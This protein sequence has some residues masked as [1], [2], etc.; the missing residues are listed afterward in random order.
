MVWQRNYF[1]H[2]IRSDYALGRVR[3]Y[4]IANPSRWTLDRYNE[5]HTGP[6]DLGQ[7]VW[8]LLKEQPNGQWEP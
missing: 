3:D 7:S 4:I 8:R 1:E 5:T 6:D 2:I